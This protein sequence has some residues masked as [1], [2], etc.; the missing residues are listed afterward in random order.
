MNSTMWSYLLILILTFVISIDGFTSTSCTRIVKTS[1]YSESSSATTS[2]PKSRFMPKRVIKATLR[3]YERLL[4]DT[5]LMERLKLS[6]SKTKILREVSLLSATLE[7]S[8]EQPCVDLLRTLRDFQLENANDDNKSSPLSP[9]STPSP[10]PRKKP[11]R[12]IL[13]GA[14]M[15]LGCAGWVFS[16][17][18]IFTSVFAI[19]VTI[20][21]LEYFR[22]VLQTG[23]YPARRISV[24]GSAAMFITALVAPRLHQIC[25]PLFATYAMIF[26]LTFKKKPSR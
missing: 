21:Q 12:S 17:D 16:G 14:L 2:K 19:L 24:V 10:P 18:Y 20:G 23:V 4:S 6:H 22:G 9:H 1:L 7:E 8:C 3:Y 15:G 26:L 25:L 5:S 11:R 13:F